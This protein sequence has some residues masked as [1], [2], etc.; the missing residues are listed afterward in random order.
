MGGIRK[1]SEFIIYNVRSFLVSLHEDDRGQATLEYVLLL[2]FTIGGTVG[3][4]KAILATLDKGVLRLGAQLEMDL[5]TGRA[6]LS[7]W[8]N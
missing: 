6:D 7:A 5:K 3:L 2:A 8:K 1:H 4:A